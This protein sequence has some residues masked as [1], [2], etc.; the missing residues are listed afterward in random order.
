MTKSGEKMKTKCGIKWQNFEGKNE[1]IDK[2]KTEIHEANIMVMKIKARCEDSLL[3]ISRLL[4][5]D[6]QYFG[7]KSIPCPVQA[8]R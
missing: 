5:T 8:W 6:D 4:R 7:I 1:K 2:M 3:L